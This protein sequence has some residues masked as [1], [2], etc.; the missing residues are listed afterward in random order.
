[1]F[2]INTDST[3]KSIKQIMVISTVATL[4]MAFMGSI[5]AMKS[6]AFNR[7][8]DDSDSLLGCFGVGVNCDKTNK[9]NNNRHND[10]VTSIINNTLG[11]GTGGTATNTTG[12]GTNTTATA[13]DNCLTGHLSHTQLISLEVALK[14]GNLV[15]LCAALHTTNL[16][17][18]SLILST[19]LHLN[20]SVV[21]ALIACLVANGFT[22]LAGLG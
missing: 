14:V 2:K 20:V 11:T 12:T 21:T 5:P 15:D 1:M 7:S 19:T 13:C 3:R 16:L 4:L 10:I 6:Y 9:D 22:N 17:S 18:L 8:S